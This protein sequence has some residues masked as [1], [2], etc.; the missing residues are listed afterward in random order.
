MFCVWK[1]S[2][3]VEITR[4]KQNSQIT[5]SVG[6]NKKRKGEIGHQPTSKLCLVV[7][8]VLL[9]LCLSS[10]VQADEWSA[11]ITATS[12]D[13]AVSYTDTNFQDCNRS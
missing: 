4:L 1:A 9:G 5:K 7:A 2:E 13:S 6:K 11:T 8:I 12:S 10:V 3:N